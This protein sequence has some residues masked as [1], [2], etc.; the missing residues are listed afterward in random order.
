M[1]TYL[2]VVKDL[3]YINM[4]VEDDQPVLRLVKDKLNAS[5]FSGVQV[6]ELVPE[7][8]FSNPELNVY[9]EKFTEISI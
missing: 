9:H 7:I 6:E 8:R 4:T 5:V 2:I 1:Q 3:G